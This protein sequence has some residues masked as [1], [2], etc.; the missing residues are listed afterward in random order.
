MPM[1]LKYHPYMILIEYQY[2]VWIV[3]FPLYTPSFGPRR[4][5]DDPYLVGLKKNRGARSLGIGRV[6]KFG[7]PSWRVRDCLEFGVKV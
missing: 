5:L 2:T 7:V 6:L 4:C 3:Q 1:Y